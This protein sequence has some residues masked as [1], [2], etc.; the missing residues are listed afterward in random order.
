MNKPRPDALEELL[1]GELRQPTGRREHFKPVLEREQF[2]ERC[3]HCRGT[4]LYFGRKGYP[5]FRCDG[6]GTRTFKTSPATRE[7]ARTRAVVKRQAREAEKAAWRKAHERELVWLESAAMRGREFPKRMI[8]AV[9]Q[10]GTLTD[11]Q[12]AAVRRWMER[13]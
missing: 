4:G 2:T 10:Y 13:D 8:E 5:C 7:K 9:A 3:P 1:D 6:R 12:L 11:A